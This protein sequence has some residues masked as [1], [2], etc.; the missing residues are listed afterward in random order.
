MTSNEEK[1]NFE[2]NGTDLL[3][4]DL[5]I[6]C[7]TRANHRAILE[8]MKQLAV[9]NNTTGASI[10]DLGNLMQAE[11]LAELNIVLK[12]TEKKANGQRQEEA[13]NNEKLK[14][15]E[16]EGRINE[17]RMQMDHEDMTQE[18]NIR[19]DILVAEIRAAAMAG[20]VDL[21]ANAQSDYLDALSQIQSSDEFGQVMA[22]D[23]EK[24][25]NKGRHNADKLQIDREKI[26]AQKEIAATNLRIAQENKNK[27]DTKKRLDKKKKGL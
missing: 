11:S 12:A 20:A 3:L 16:N 2:M 9:G 17:L 14:Q 5:N 7:T 19:K 25:S 1:V 8:Q 22:F 21:N 23:Q 24:E 13:Q 27:F 26:A 4:R 6:Y 15:M 10:Y 18:K